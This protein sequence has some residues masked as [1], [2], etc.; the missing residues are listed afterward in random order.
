MRLDKADNSNMPERIALLQRYLALFGA[1]SVQFLLV[2][3]LPGR[4]CLHAREGEFIHCRQGMR[5]CPKGD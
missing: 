5:A 3:P 4:A 1:G 2:D